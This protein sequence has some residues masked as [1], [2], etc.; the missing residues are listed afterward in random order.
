MVALHKDLPSFPTLEDFVPE[1]DWGEVRF[2][3]GGRSFRILYG[4]EY[5]YI[6]DFL[7]AFKLIYGTLDE[8]LES[9]FGTSPL[10]EL[11]HVLRFQD[12]TI[13]SL[14]VVQAAR[15]DVEIGPGHIEIPPKSFWEVA[16]CFYRSFRP[17]QAIPSS[18]LNRYSHVLGDSAGPLDYMG[19]GNATFEGDVLRAMFV[20]SGTHYFPVLPRRHSTLLRTTWVRRNGEIHGTVA[21]QL[22]GATVH[23]AIHEYVQARMN[24][25]LKEAF[26][27][28]MLPDGRR[29]SIVPIFLFEFGAEC[30]GDSLFPAFHVRGDTAIMGR[31]YSTQACRS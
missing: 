8:E 17:E 16:S 25:S 14:E 3:L 15:E 9:Q 18:F 27:S 1:I 21:E 7:M 31:R 5:S 30:C 22:T 12:I 26:V 24:T 20:K 23:L 2:P 11:G 29:R 6:Y 4:S 19:F 13:E 10:D 28:P